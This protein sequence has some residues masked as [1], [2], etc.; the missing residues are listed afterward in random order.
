MRES[1]SKQVSVKCCRSL[2]DKLVYLPYD[3]KLCVLKNDT[4][5]SIQDVPKI[6]CSDNFDQPAQTVRM[7][8]HF[9]S[10][11]LSKHP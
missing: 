2:L 3:A 10:E 6:P 9:L 5:D 1:V 4:I 7:M 8:V 11:D